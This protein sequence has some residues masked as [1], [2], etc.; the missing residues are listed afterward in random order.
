MGCIQKEKVNP[1]AELARNHHKDNKKRVRHLSI[2]LPDD[3]YDR[4][5]DG[6]AQNTSQTKDSKPLVV[7]RSQQSQQFS[8]ADTL[9]N[10]AQTT[11]ANGTAPEFAKAYGFLGYTV[12]PC[13]VYQQG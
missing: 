4:Y 7:N 5:Q 10:S 13:S 6:N 8:R 1:D 3:N 9:P 2:Q 12:N 11:I